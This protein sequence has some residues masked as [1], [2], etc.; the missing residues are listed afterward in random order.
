M[1]SRGLVAIVLM[2]LGIVVLA[3]SGIAFPVRLGAVG[4]G[5]V[6]FPTTG[7]VDLPG[8]EGIAHHRKRR[9]E[10]IAGLI[11]AALTQAQVSL[12]AL[13]HRRVAAGCGGLRKDFPCRIQ[14][15]LRDLPLPGPHCQIGADTVEP[16]AFEPTE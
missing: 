2:V 11:G 5:Y 9:L 4:N 14:R 8:Q 10:Q 13:H 7:A 15:V 12:F 1:N 6:M 3:Y 16:S